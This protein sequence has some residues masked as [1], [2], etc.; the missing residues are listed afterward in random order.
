[1]VGLEA[2]AALRVI[3][4]GSRDWSDPN[5]ARKLIADRLFDLPV[6]SV[7]VHGAARGADRFA[8]QEAQKLGLLVEPHPA[9]WDT[10]GKSAGFR[11]NAEMI[12]LGADLVLAFWNGKS[13]GTKH[14]I[15]LA[16]KAGIPVEVLSL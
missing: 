1:L 7:I 13:N 11:R 3:I 8:H 2:G 12:S 5:A 4:T 16:H 6:E 10:Y 14:T 15:D 9:D